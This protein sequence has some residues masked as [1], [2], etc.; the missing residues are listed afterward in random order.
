[1]ADFDP[2]KQSRD[3]L[4]R[5]AGAYSTPGVDTHPPDK[6]FAPLTATPIVRFKLQDVDP[7]SPVYVRPFDALNLHVIT[8]IAGGATVTFIVRILRADGQVILN[9]FVVTASTPGVGVNVPQNLPEGYLLSVIASGPNN[10]VRGQTFAA[11]TLRYLSAL[12]GAVVDNLPL[13]ADYVTASTPVGWPAGEVSQPTDR[14]GHLRSITGTAPAAGA[15]INEVVP[16]TT[17]WRLLAFRYTLTTAVAAANRES[18]LQIDD[19][20]NP[21]ATETASFTQIA[22]LAFIYSWSIGFTR[23]AALQSNLISSA[24]P[25][26]IVEAGHRI[27]TSTSNI[28]AADQY[29]APQYLVEEWLTQG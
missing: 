15:E 24:L 16:S 21:Y 23:Q 18:N 2:D 26:F 11:A 28:Q 29:S 22:S 12:T 8:L 10:T 7:P 19:G 6:P 14:N 9:T 4:N 13:F 3:A 27:R 1:V 20:V 17:R 5:G 25:G